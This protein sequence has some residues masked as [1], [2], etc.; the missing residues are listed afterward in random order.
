MTSKCL[1]CYPIYVNESIKIK[2]LVFGLFSI[3]I[4]AIISSSY[5]MD[6]STCNSPKYSQFCFKIGISNL[7]ILEVNKFSILNSAFNF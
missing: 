3:S 6:I 2:A 5:L 1:S 4:I 7:I